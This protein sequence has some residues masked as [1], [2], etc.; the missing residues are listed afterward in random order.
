MNDATPLAPGDRVMMRDGTGP[1]TVVSVSLYPANVMLMRPVIWDENP[2]EVYFLPA[3]LLVP[4]KTEQEKLEE[5]ALSLG[6]PNPPKANV[7]R[8]LAK[9]AEWERAL[10]NWSDTVRKLARDERKDG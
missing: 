8:Y 9:R 4:Y 1:G 10:R 6:F 3:E 2:H 5:L 7:E